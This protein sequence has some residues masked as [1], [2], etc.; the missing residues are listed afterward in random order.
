MIF[1]LQEEAVGVNA[2]STSR[3]RHRLSNSVIVDPESDVRKSA[4]RLPRFR[5]S[6]RGKRCADGD[7][8]TADNNYDQDDEDPQ[9]E[10]SI[11]QADLCSPPTVVAASDD[12]QPSTNASGV[13]SSVQRASSISTRPSAQTTDQINDRIDQLSRYNL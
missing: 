5:K 11:V 9:G 12:A 2:A 13:E 4:Y 8:D 10:S 6:K 1:M 7:D 3:Q